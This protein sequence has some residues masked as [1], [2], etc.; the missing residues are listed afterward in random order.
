ML[1]ELQWLQNIFVP[2]HFV[3]TNS[4]LWVRFSATG[5]MDV[6][7]VIWIRWISLQYSMYHLFK[8]IPKQSYSFYYWYLM[9]QHVLSTQN[10]TTIPGQKQFSQ[11]FTDEDHGSW[12]CYLETHLQQK[13]TWCNINLNLHLLW[14]YST[15][16]VVDIFRASR[17]RC[18]G[19]VI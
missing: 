13:E 1:P 5:Y 3:N 16:S 8:Y 10:S 14:P 11:D 6:Y 12:S 15:V 19:A 2:F 18:N 17:A 4:L 9:R 7:E